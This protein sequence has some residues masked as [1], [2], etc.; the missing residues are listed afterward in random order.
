VNR[1]YAECRAEVTGDRLSGHAAVWNTLAKIRGGYE[2]IERAAVDGILDRSDVR[3]LVNHDPSKLLARQG[4][5]TLKLATDDSGLYWEIPELPNTSYAHDLRESVA[6][7]DIDGCSFGFRPG[8]IRSSVA[9]DGRQ[10]RTHTE[11]GDLMDVSPVTFPAYDGT[12]LALRSVDF[13]QTTDL[14]S[15]LIRIRHSLLKQGVHPG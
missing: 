3:A 6:R 4:A 1:L 15:Q 8:K 14:R 7:G 12:D 11:L 13:T 9:P 2:A 5:G 10:V